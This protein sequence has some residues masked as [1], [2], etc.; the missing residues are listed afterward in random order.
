MDVT[1]KMM[2]IKQVAA[3]GVLSEHALRILAKQGKL[4]C[5][6]IGR[7]CLINYGLLITKLNNLDAVNTTTA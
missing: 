3:T 2:T 5:I 6:H 1:P 4:P 7:K